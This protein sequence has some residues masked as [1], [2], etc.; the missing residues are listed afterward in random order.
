MENKNNFFA[1]NI[2]WWRKVNGV[3]QT[4]FSKRIDKKTS[5]ISAYE[6]GISTP[7]L[8]V[9][10]K[11]ADITGFSFVDLMNIDLSKFA[12][13]KGTE[14]GNLKSNLIPLK[15]DWFENATENATEN[16]NS[17]DL[18]IAIG[19]KT[20]LIDETIEIIKLLSRKYKYNFREDITCSK[21]YIQSKY[22]NYRNLIK[23]Y[24]GKSSSELSFEYLDKTFFVVNKCYFAILEDLQVFTSIIFI[25]SDEGKIEL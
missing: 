11:I 14:K 17:W 16:A 24:E 18:I 13:L 3:S 1:S 9:I 8:A 19:E 6:K 22:L 23:E 10:M 15:T 20:N 2:R 21:F 5:V 4:E 7:P 12:E 25:L